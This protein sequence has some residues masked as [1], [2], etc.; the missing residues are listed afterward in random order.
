[1]VDL[2]LYYLRQ[3]IYFA[4]RNL[5]AAPPGPLRRRRQLVERV[6]TLGEVVT[7]RTRDVFDRYRRRGVE[8]LALLGVA[9][10]DGTHTLAAL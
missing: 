9:V 6:T 7:N 8:Q 4:V 5:R 3:C 1:M 2:I 10:G